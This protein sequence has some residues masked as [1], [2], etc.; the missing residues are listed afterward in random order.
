MEHHPNLIM[1][2]RAAVRAGGAAS[3]APG[4]SAMSAARRVEAVPPHLLQIPDL[5]GCL[6]S[7]PAS[8]GPGR[9]GA[10]GGIGSFIIAQPRFIL[11]SINSSTTEGSA[12]VDVSP[13]LP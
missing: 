2:D 10:A 7:I 8:D 12:N 6:N 3:S 13:R 11:F 9:I 1:D 5:A 4:P